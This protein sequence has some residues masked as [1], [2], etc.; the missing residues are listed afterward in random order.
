MKFASLKCFKVTAR[1]A[2]T[3]LKTLIPL[4]GSALGPRGASNSPQTPFFAEFRPRPSLRH[5]ILDPPPAPPMIVNASTVTIKIGTSTIFHRYMELFGWVFLY[6]INYTHKRE[7][8]KRE[9]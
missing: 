6:F 8:H 9:R 4:P 3:V 1:K 2:S 7:N 5:R